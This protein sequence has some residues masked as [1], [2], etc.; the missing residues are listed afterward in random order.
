MSR[1]ILCFTSS[2]VLDFKQFCWAM[3]KHGFNFVG[4]Q[5]KPDA[6]LTAKHLPNLDRLRRVLEAKVNAIFEIKKVPNNLKM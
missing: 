5:V 2:S 4:S 1:T 3:T 6:F